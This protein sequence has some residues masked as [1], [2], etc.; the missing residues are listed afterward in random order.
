[1]REIVAIGP[2]VSLEIEYL[3]SYHITPIYVLLKLV[4]DFFVLMKVSIKFGSIPLQL[5]H[6]LGK[7]ELIFGT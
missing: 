7:K 3:F 2:S 1:L 6:W 5:I 4:Y